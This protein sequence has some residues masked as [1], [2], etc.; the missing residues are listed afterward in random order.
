MDKEVIWTVSAFKDLQSI[1]NFIA[2]DSPY[3]AMT[4]YEDVMDKAQTLKHFP[5]RGR[6]V[7]ELDDPNMWEFFLHRYRLIYQI[8]DNNVIITTIMHGS[9]D[10]KGK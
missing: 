6:V 5:H 2:E 4:L 8:R 10:Y 1:Y 3:Y 7:P 9:R